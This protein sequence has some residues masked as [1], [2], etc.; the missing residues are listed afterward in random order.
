LVTAALLTL[1]VG[2][3]SVTAIFSVV[4]GVLLKPLSYQDPDRLV[5][6]YHFTPGLSQDPKGPQTPAS[7]FT[8]RENGRA[9]AD[10]GLI[11]W[12]PQD[13][14]VSRDGEQQQEQVRAIGVTDGVLS[15]LGVRPVLGRLFRAE[16]DRPGAPNRVLLTDALWQSMFNAS[17]HVLGRSLVVA[18]PEAAPYEIIGVLPASFRAPTADVQLFIPLKL[19]RATA[20]PGAFAY[21]GLARLKPGVSPATASADITRMIP[22]ITQQF[23]LPPQITPQMWEELGLAPN[24]MPLADD[25]IGQTRQP[26]WILLGTVTLVLFLAWTNVAN[27]LL[28]RAEGRQRE[29]AVHQALG[30]SRIRIATELLSETLMLGLA[31]GVLGILLA[32]SG[33][34]LLRQIAP[35]ALPRVEDIGLDGTVLLFTLTTSIATSILFGL[36]PVLRCHR[37][38]FAILKE[39]GRSG[40]DGPGRHRT[41]NTLVVVQVAVAL[42]LLIASGLMVRTFMAM[43][44]VQ[45]GY[46]RPAEVLTFELSLTQGVVPDESQ[47]VGTFQRIA[48][49]LE[50]APGVTAVALAGNLI[51][52]ATPVVPV[53]VEDRPVAGLA[54]PRKQ[55]TVSP[56]YFTAMGNPVLAGRAFTWNDILQSTNTVIISENLAREY[57]GEPANALGKRITRRPAD[58][59][60][61]IVGVVGNERDDGLNQPAATTTFWPMFALRSMKFLVRSDRVGTPGFVRELQQSVWSVKPHLP[62]ASIRTLGEIQA[63][64]M[65]PTSFAMTMLAIAAG[66]AVLLGVV[67][68]YGV[69]R[70]I[71]EQRTREVGIRMALGAQTGDVRRLFLRQGLI[72]ALSGIALG[73]GSALIFSSIMSTLLFGVRPIDALTY[74]AAAALLTGVSALA[75]Y[76]PARHASAVDAVVA[77][78]SDA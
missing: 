60:S 36:I 35:V 42:V 53:F 51:M 62:L 17:R 68:L 69:V 3:G 15:I 32:Q 31:G 76:L 38:N 26:L 4:Y 29:L 11:D 12:E 67:G 61:E 64:S 5:S 57:W 59:W 22:L 39:S 40:S 13:V 65:A 44:S 10:I 18:A 33:I 37:P 8:Y 72:L 20:S 74:G 23:P 54:A 46:V 6:L 43:R 56:D 30:A 7:Y 45:P 1:A 47:V 50:Q 19:D 41:R 63:Q 21:R 24:V 55:R 70:Y 66:V 71:A 16:D 52:G 78:R 28:V 58:P 9:F 73:I 25:V 48:E 77:M 34:A 2:I 27:L 49:A 14:F 75:T